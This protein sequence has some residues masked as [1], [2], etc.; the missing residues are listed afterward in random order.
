M[1]LVC[2]MMIICRR[3]GIVKGTG[4]KM[5]RRLVEVY[6]GSTNAV[7]PPYIQV[8]AKVVSVSLSTNI[9]YEQYSKP[10]RD[11]VP[12]LPA[13]PII[14]FSICISC[15]LASHGVLQRWPLGSTR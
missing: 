13:P 14:F 15:M 9:Q 10:I 12:Y 5:V 6:T 2:G 1:G 3:I 7:Y 11:P 4:M 8:P